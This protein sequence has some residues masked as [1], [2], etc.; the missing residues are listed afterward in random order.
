[1]R[2]EKHGND[3]AHENQRDPSESGGVDLPPEKTPQFVPE[4]GFLFG[5]LVRLQTGNGSNFYFVWHAL[6]KIPRNLEA[7]EE[8]R[9][10]NRHEPA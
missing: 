4:L 10:R 7:G 2:G 3:E 9:M 6:F 5:F 8:N 1:M